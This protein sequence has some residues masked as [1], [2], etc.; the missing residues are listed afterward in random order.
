MAEDRIILA[1]GSGGGL[2]HK[3]IKEIFVPAFYHEGENLSDAALLQD[4]NGEIAFT[5]DSFV[6]EPRFFPGGDI[7]HLA[8]CGTVNDLAVSGAIPKYLSAGFIIEEGFGV[9]ELKRI[10]ASMAQTAQKAGVNIVTGDT[11]VV[12]TGPVLAWCPKAEI[13]LPLGLRKGMLLF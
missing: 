2:Y 5:T 9:P 8:V 6:I 3:L 11:K 1:H 13:W 12:K 4:L 7:G 10:C